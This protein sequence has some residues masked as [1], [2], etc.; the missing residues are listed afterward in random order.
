[1]EVKTFGRFVG[2]VL[3]DNRGMRL[4]LTLHLRLKHGGL[5]KIV[6][7]KSRGQLPW[8]KKGSPNGAARQSEVMVKRTVILR[9][10]PVT[11]YVR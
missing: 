1:M 5:P 4:K 6:E 11:G 8:F 10:I 9:S 2:T 7:P 3:Y